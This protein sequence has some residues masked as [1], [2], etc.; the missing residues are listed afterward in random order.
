MKLS[1]LRDCC[2]Q[3]A[4][5]GIERKKRHLLLPVRASAGTSRV[6]MSEDTSGSYPSRTSLEIQNLLVSHYQ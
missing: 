2:Y 4:S 6:Q 3:P 5:G 1:F